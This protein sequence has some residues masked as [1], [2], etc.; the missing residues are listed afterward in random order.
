MS[1]EDHKTLATRFVEEAFNRGNLA[2]IDEVFAPTYINHSTPPGLPP[3]PAG[4][5]HFVA[6]W[7]TA[8]PDVCM[9]VEDLVTEGEKVV[10]RWTATGTHAG[11]L[12]GVSP[13]GRRAAVSGIDI[14]RIADH[15]I[16]EGWGSFDQLGLLR[17]LGAI[18]TPGSSAL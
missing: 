17:Q 18:P 10:I 6:M 9:T 4:T 5:K 15:K 1:T 2:I 7:R 14:V 3:G 12:M 16:V 11:P 8:F 13:T